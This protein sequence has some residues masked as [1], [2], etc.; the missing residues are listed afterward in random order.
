MLHW[1]VLSVVVQ[2]VLC[3]VVPVFSVVSAPTAER[4]VI[5]EPP[6][7]IPPKPP[8]PS[9]QSGSLTAGDTDDNLNFI[10]Y[11]L[12]AERIWN[13]D[14]QVESN[15]QYPLPMPDT[16]AG[17]ISVSVT[18]EVSNAFPC[19]S[20]RIASVESSAEVQLFTGSDGK[21]A[22][23]P[24][25]DDIGEGPW[26]LT[27]TTPDGQITSDTINDITS[28]S[29][30]EIII[31]AV[32]VL[33][34]AMDLA[35]VLDTTGSMC[36]EI[37]FLKSE[38]RNVIRSFIDAI[39]RTIDLKIGI[40]FYKDTTDEYTTLVEDF[41]DTDSAL[42][43]LASQTCNGGGDYP[44]AVHD[45]WQQAT[46]LTWREDNVARV[47]FLIGDAPPHREDI[48]E[49]FAAALSLRK[50]GVRLYGLA[51]SDTNDVLEYLLRMVALISHG[52]HMW[53]T[54]DS[55]I[56]NSKTD[57]KVACFQVTDLE[58]LLSRVLLGEMDG[59]RI[60]PDPDDV[61]REV[62]SQNGGICLIDLN[63]PESALKPSENGF[64]AGGGD[65]AGG[66][67][68]AEYAV[69]FPGPVIDEEIG[70]PASP[71]PAPTPLPPLAL[72]FPGDS[73]V[74]V[75]GIGH[76]PLRDL[77]LGD[78]VNV[79]GDK[80]SEVYSFG[81]H[82]PH[83]KAEY[84]HLFH[85]NNSNS[86][87]KISKDHM[88]FVQ[89]KH[90]QAALRA[91]PASLVTVGDRIRMGSTGQLVTVTKIIVSSGIG[92][93]APFTLTGSIVVDHVMVSNYV[94]LQQNSGTFLIGGT[95]TPISMQFL[96]HAFQA[97]H[98]ILCHFAWDY[99]K[100]EAYNENGV[101]TWVSSPLALFEYVLSC[102]WM[103]MALA[104]PI[105]ISLALCLHVVEWVIMNWWLAVPLY[106]STTLLFHGL[107]IRKQQRQIL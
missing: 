69:G 68:G 107:G 29:P 80:Y 26:S 65:I 87:L 89:E 71:T 78:L 27:A 4:D 55:G 66:D 40:V 56:G 88:V 59:V 97:H 13:E 12:Y 58:K 3:D 38:L 25:L 106:L 94:S 8:G 51:A 79:G 105:I 45:A 34:N 52:R 63:D 5:I 104:A 2:T 9:Q 95:K 11:M 46:N 22:V 82:D 30:V 23:F 61:V 17:R 85:S 48:D 41:T 67:A 24:N 20:V 49:A 42:D 6:F 103:W 77:K 74:D 44:E 36:D 90:S 39:D 35:I 102:H 99:C 81:H 37:E 84:I 70:K 14:A 72:C 60:E 50:K 100:D 53:L 98:R 19:A 91:M 32:P 28:D 73:V 31:P 92:A 83:A 75:L 86:R 93:F 18:D 10:T 21:L 62:G 57:A 64:A 1:F 43:A 7:G 54:N 16:V 76:V 33:P 101:S 15:N 47:A 96:A